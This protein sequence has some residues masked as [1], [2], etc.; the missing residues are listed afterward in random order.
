MCKGEFGC[1][2]RIGVR[3]IEHHDAALRCGGHVDVVDADARSANGPQPGAGGDHR[4][5]D[6][7]LGANDESIVVRYARGERRL[8]EPRLHV[9]MESGIAC[10]KLTAVGVDRVRDQHAIEG[11]H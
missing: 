7:R 1:R 8:V 2:R 4:S 6:P 9:D 5:G 10:K 11:I 3:R